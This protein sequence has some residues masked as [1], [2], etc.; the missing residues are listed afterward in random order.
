MK[1]LVTGC[2][3]FIGSHFSL[4]LMEKYP[5]D[6]I[7]G[8]DAM[9][10]AANEEALESLLAYRQ[11]RFYKENICNEGAIQHIFAEEHP[12]IVVNFA[13]ETHV[14]RSISDASPFL[15]TNVIG[16]Q[17]LLE[18][19]A[20]NNVRRFH[21]VSTDEVYGDVPL[22]INYHFNE[23][24][25]LRP[26]SPY[27]ASKASADLLAQ[28]Y[29]RT[30]GLPVSI[31]RCTNNYGIY[32]HP[33]KLI[34]KTISRICEGKAVE[35]Y[36][37]GNNVRDWLYVGDHCRAIDLIIRKGKCEVYNVGADNLRSNIDLVRKIMTLSG[38]P[39]GEIRFVQDRKGHDRKYLINCRKLTSLGWQPEADFERELQNTVEWYKSKK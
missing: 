15:Q 21:Q 16:T 36:G 18:A 38:K 7:V 27:S 28:S 19:S 3:G 30:F 37:N 20:Q 5:E 39:D 35:L 31:S 10:Y 33:E 6:S 9:T 17:I 23:E 25:A 8:V 1:I 2:A 34:P 11:F 26:S 22:H 14:D 4:Y 24:S 29:M 12:D 13:A 32:Q